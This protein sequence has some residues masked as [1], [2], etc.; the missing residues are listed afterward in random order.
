MSDLLSALDFK[1]AEPVWR[2]TIRAFVKA[3]LE[4]LPEFGGPQAAQQA[5]LKELLKDLSDGIYGPMEV[6]GSILLGSQPRCLIKPTPCGGATL[7]VGS[8]EYFHPK[9]P[10]GREAMDDT[11]KGLLESIGI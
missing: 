7:T 9:Q 11:T 6:N 4:K 3:T 8:Y 5:R 2:E 1:H 10:E